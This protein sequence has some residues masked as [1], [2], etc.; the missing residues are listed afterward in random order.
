MEHT[1]VGSSVF[2]P[3]LGRRRLKQWSMASGTLRLPF[4]HGQARMLKNDF[5]YMFHVYM[6]IF[7][8]YISYFIIY[9]HIYKEKDCKKIII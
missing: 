8:V 9:I 5:I 7:H 4:T 2:S 3:S 6:Y 1:L